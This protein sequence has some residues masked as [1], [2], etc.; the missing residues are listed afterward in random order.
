MKT[1]LEKIYNN[2]KNNPRNKYM[3]S[4][5]SI[6]CIIIFKIPKIKSIRYRKLRMFKLFSVRIM[7]LKFVVIFALRPSTEISLLI[8]LEEFTN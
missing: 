6:G 8:S 5:D 2:H 1:I 3:K 7:S 4:G